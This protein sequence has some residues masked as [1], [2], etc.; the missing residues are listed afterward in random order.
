[1]NFSTE[2]DLISSYG[3]AEAVADRLLIDLPAIGC[4]V[5]FQGRVVNRMTARLFEELKPFLIDSEGADTAVER[6]GLSPGCV[7]ALVST[8]TT[9]LVHALDTAGPGEERDYLYQLPGGSSDRIWLIRNEAGG[10]T[11]MFASDR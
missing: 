1:M 9:K 8:L 2:D 4:H 3:D 5:T 7:R 11:V 6:D 10:W